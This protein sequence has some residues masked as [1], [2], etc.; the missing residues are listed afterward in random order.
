MGVFPKIVQI[1]NIQQ[2]QLTRKLCC[3]K[4]GMNSH[5]VTIWMMCGFAKVSG[6]LCQQ[7]LSKTCILVAFTVLQSRH[8][9]LSC[10]LVPLEFIVTKTVPRMITWAVARYITWSA[11]TSTVYS[12]LGSY[13]AFLALG[14]SLLCFF[15][16]SKKAYWWNLVMKLAFLRKYVTAYHCH[17]HFTTHTLIQST[18]FDVCIWLSTMIM[19]KVITY[20]GDE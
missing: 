6:Y 17:A 14:S 15:K 10:Y 2:N 5:K 4:S 19:E 1:M 12:C 20:R 9:S 3:Y 16:E 8:W 13:C 7:I 11:S 18:S